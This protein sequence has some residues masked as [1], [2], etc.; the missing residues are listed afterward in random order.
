MGIT[1]EV[2]ARIRRQPETALLAAPA[3]YLFLL[4]LVAVLFAR[5]TRLIRKQ[6]RV[7]RGV[8]GASLE[9][10][11]IAHDGR[12][13]DV[14]ARLERIGALGE[15]NAE[16]LRSALRRVGVV[17]YDAFS[18]IGGQQSF[19]VAL[20][21][22]ENNGVVLSGIHSRSDLRVYAKPV[23]AGDSPLTLTGEEQGAI[24]QALDHRTPDAR[25]QDARAHETPEKEV[26]TAWQAGMRNG[27]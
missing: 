24:T 2:V 16:A 13:V 10:M 11:L 15:A 12:M 7:L 14:T 21:D 22:G 9:R 8:D 26:T 4:A 19:S 6:A 27:G 18:D 1:G 17:R 3:L 5:Q 25:A 20:L 23:V